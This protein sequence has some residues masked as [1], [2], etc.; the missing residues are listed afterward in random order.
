MEMSANATNAQDIKETIKEAEEAGHYPN[1]ESKTEE[2]TTNTDSVEAPDQ[3]KAQMDKVLKIEAQK[4]KEKEQE[5]EE[6][7]KRR[8][9]SQARS[10]STAEAPGR[11]DDD[12]ERPS[13]WTMWGAIDGQVEYDVDP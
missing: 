9:R 12:D 7:E 2:F 4:V 5:R 1:T 11:D 10:P 8:Q 13:R 3:L 6:E